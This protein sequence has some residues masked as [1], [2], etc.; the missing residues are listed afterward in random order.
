MLL[1]VTQEF[2]ELD[3]PVPI[4]PSTFQTLAF[5]FFDYERTRYIQ[6]S[7]SLLRGQL[8]FLRNQKHR[9]SLGH[10]AQN[11]RK[12]PQGAGWKS[13][14]GMTAVAICDLYGYLYCV[15]F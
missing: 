13:Q 4:Y 3:S 14:Y 15:G 10:L 11:V 6:E 12:K 7:R 1:L 8:K 2:L 5:N 9:F